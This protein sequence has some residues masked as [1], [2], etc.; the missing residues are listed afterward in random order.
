MRPGHLPPLPSSEARGRSPLPAAP[1]LSWCPGPS[2]EPLP[3]ILLL[4]PGPRSSKK[5]SSQGEQTAAPSIPSLLR[6]QTPNLRPLRALC[7]EVEGADR[8]LDLLSRPWCQ[9]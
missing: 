7:P 3:A 1:V 6:A 2:P 8:N 9:C 5:W 4:G